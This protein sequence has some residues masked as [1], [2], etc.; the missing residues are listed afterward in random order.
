MPRF[1]SHFSIAGGLHQ[2][3][4]AVERYGFKTLQLFTKAPSQWGAA[5]H[6]PDE[7]ARFRRLRRQLRLHRPIVHA[8][9]LINIAS[10]SDDLW[11][12]S[13]DA[14]VDEM[15][16][17]EAIEASDLVLHVGAHSG[18]GV[19]HGIRRAIQA[20]DEVTSRGLGQSV[21]ILLETTAGH[22]TTLG[23]RFEH[24]AEI[25]DGV[26][27]PQ[28][29]GVCFDTCHVFAAGYPLSPESAYRQTMREFDRVIGLRQIRA[30]HLNDSKRELGSGLDRHAHIG[31]GHLGLEP[32]RLLVN[33]YR[34]RSKSMILETPK[35]TLPGVGDMDAE[36]YRVLRELLSNGSSH[37][38][39]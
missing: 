11:R 22:G 23:H 14:L 9:Y 31:R 34:F 12:R 38:G 33:D 16:R 1:G 26:Q 5:P 27:D 13:I 10:P 18:Q 19:E 6:R 30:F 8:G 7:L 28:R 20:L 32:F 4:L 29:F 39:P 25:L 24:L 2:A 21:R 3:L 36:N 35:E 15:E 37:R 17:A